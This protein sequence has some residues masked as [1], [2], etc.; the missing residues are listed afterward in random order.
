MLQFR[1]K[2]MSSTTKFLFAIVLLSLVSCDRDTPLEIVDDGIPPAKPLGLRIFGAHDGEIGIE[3]NHNLEKDIAFYKI[4]RTINPNNLYSLIDSTSAIYYI[5]YGLE[6]D[7][8]Y[9]YKISAVDHFGNESVMSDSVFA[10]PKNIFVPLPPY[11]ININARNWDDSLTF[12]ITFSPS[13]SSDVAYYEVHRSEN[14]LFTP[15]SFSLVGISEKFSYTDKADLELLKKYYYKIISVDKGGFKSQP[16][17][18]VNDI[19][20]DTP[21]LISP[22]NNAEVNY[23]AEF[24]IETCSLPADYKLVLQS[25]EIYGTKVELNFSSNLSNNIISVSLRNVTFEPYADYY[26]RVYTYTKSNNIPNSFSELYKFTIVP[27]G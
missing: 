4:F 1:K 17:T 14:S 20:L 8:T 16:S 19:L 24:K 2:V 3:W 27:G 21:K 5:D 11:Y 25:N 26:W 6:Y 15:D 12:K 23:F 18:E 7:S 13:F 22:Q 10:T 9:Y